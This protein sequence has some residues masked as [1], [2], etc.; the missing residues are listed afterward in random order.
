MKFSPALKVHFV[1][2]SDGNIHGSDYKSVLDVAKK[3]PR[4]QCHALIKSVHPNERKLSRDER[5]TTCTAD[6]DES[7]PK[8]VKLLRAELRRV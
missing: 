4:V 1:F 7:L 2:V 8:L 5:V 6:L 3:C